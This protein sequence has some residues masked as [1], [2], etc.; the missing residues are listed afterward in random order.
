MFDQTS[1]SLTAFDQDSRYF[2]FETNY[3][4]LSH[5]QRIYVT[6]V[7]EATYVKSVA[8]QIIAIAA[9]NNLSV[10]DAL[11]VITAK[12]EARQLV[13]Q[14][15]RKVSA[16]RSVSLVRTYSPKHEK[17]VTNP[18]AYAT[19]RTFGVFAVT[20]NQAIYTSTAENGVVAFYSTNSLLIQHQPRRDAL[21]HS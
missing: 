6:S 9:H 15:E 2:L 14:N 3:A 13:A 17:A 4:D 10:L 19:D 11:Q 12:H 7:V 16:E 20:G 1:F 8:N 18:P 21:E 5:H